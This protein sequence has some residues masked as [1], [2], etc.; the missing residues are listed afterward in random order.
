LLLAKVNGA[1]EQDGES[2]LK[3]Y[4]RRTLQSVSKMWA[5]SA[6]RRAFLK[7]GLS[8]F[9]IELSIVGGGIKE[10]HWIHKDQLKEFQPL[11]K[12]FQVQPRRWVVERT[13]AWL[14]RNRRLSKDYEYL[15]EVSESYMYIGMARLLLRRMIKN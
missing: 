13:F 7:E 2:C 11:P 10:G 1:N 8:S 14:N 6:Y 3:M 15:P 12:T 4:Q 9:G 5:D